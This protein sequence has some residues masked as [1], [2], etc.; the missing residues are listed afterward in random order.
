MIIRSKFFGPLKDLIGKSRLVMEVP[1]DITLLKFIHLISKQCEPKF[2]NKILMK[3]G[4][5]QSNIKML[6]NGRNIVH[7]NHLETELK[8]NDLVAFFHIAGGG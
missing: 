1:P 2:L 5:L 4:S 6:V 8:N 7:I 3:N